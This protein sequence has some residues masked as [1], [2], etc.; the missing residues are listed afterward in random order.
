METTLPSNTEIPATL[1]NIEYAADTE[2]DRYV[3]TTLGEDECE[4]VHTLLDRLAARGTLCPDHVLKY[5]VW[6]PLKLSQEESI[7]AQFLARMSSGM[8]TSTNM[9]EGMLDFMHQINPH[10]TMPKSVDKC[11]E[12]VETAHARMIAPLQRRS[13]TVSIPEEVQTLTLTLT[14]S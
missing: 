5:L 6:G 1:D 11:W 10:C 12:V 2:S 3:H 9:M 13:I 14:H 8:G 7:V 4:T